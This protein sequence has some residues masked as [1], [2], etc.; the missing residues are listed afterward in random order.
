MCGIFEVAEETAHCARR[1]HVVVDVRDERDII[2]DLLCASGIGHRKDLLEPHGI[3]PRCIGARRQQLQRIIDLQ[4]VPSTGL[5]E[6]ILKRLVAHDRMYAVEPGFGHS[7]LN[8]A[9]RIT[10][11]IAAV[12][13]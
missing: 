8:I 7:R 3:D 6:C 11:R 5:L 2:T 10:V 4:S 1:R 12:P 9:S 13:G